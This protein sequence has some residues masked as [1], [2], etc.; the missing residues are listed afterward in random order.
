[1]LFLII[2]WVSW[3]VLAYHMI[4]Y[5]LVL[6]LIN[7]FKSIPPTKTIS[8][9]PTIIVLCAA[10][11]E[12][13]VIGEKIESF[14]S[15]D[16]P[17]DKIKMIVISDNS[18]DATNEIVSRYTNYNVEL[19]IQRPRRGKQSAHNMVLPG[20]NCD[21]VLSTDANSIFEPNSVSL[22][23]R[24]MQS[25]PKLG[26]VTGELRLQKKGNQQSGE[27]LYWRYET[28]LKVMDSKFRSVICANG[29]LFLIKREFFTPIDLQSADDFERT[30]IVLK[31]HALVAYEPKA[32]VTEDET[33]KASEEISRKIRIITQEWFALSRNA[34]LLNP[35]RFPLI[36]FLLVSHKLIRW[37]FF[38]FVLTGLISSLLLSGITFYCIVF[39]MQLMVYSLGMLGLFMQKRNV[40]IP[41]TGIAAYIVAMIYS[42]LVAFVNYVFNR[43][44]FGFWKPIR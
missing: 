37:L 3:L 27:G 34:T 33:Q 15:L 40:R 1:M 18:T 39:I 23:V 13:K 41:F 4:G 43:S 17:K 38:V 19:V 14:L 20:L 31:N 36:S 32:I 16:Y 29:A 21:Y 7:L 44:N 8:N 5:G 2:F 10:Y 11:N 35:F 6:Y 42:S 9:F 26:M 25:N 30:L 12:E 22:L 28:F 24:R